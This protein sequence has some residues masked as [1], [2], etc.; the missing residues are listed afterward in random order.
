MNQK[1][2]PEKDDGYTHE[3]FM[4]VSG[5]A[6]LPPIPYSGK[7]PPILFSQAIST[8][9][10][11]RSIDEAKVWPDNADALAAWAKLYKDDQVGREARALKLHAYRRIGVLAGQIRPIRYGGS[12]GIQGPN[13][14]LVEHGISKT[15]A[16]QMR[17]IALMP[18]SKF[19]A[20]AKSAKPP[21]PSVL[22]GEWLTSNPK[23]SHFARGM[24]GFIHRSRKHKI[25]D[26]VE[27][28]SS[29][30]KNIAYDLCLK[31]CGTLTD[32][33]AYLEGRDPEI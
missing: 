1:N 15:K 18:E 23:W 26:L 3:E 21:S 10:A 31:M 4:A 14:L 32:L 29:E 22:A 9:A 16:V 19:S 20:I 11:C 27:S 28:L 30:Q 25:K 2:E 7:Q 24:H 12:K 8:L 13:S 5:M 17:R 6:P 33:M